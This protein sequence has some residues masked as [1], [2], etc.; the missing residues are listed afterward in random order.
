MWLTWIFGICLIILVLF[1]CVKLYEHKK[2]KRT[3]VS[4]IFS[5]FDSKVI[6][7]NEKGEK[8]LLKFNQS[9]VLFVS[10]KIPNHSRNLQAKLVDSLRGHY[11]KVALDDR[12]AR[13]LNGNGTNSHFLKEISK[14]KGNGKRRKKDRI[15]D[16]SLTNSSLSSF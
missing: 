12:G 2:E 7:L 11:K 4:S 5:R 8:V 16:D 9:A 13:V 3:F 15:D 1:L 14:E 6:S 10:E